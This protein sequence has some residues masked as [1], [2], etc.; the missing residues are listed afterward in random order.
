[1]AKAKTYS[2]E[3]WKHKLN[4]CFIVVILISNASKCYNMITKDITGQSAVR[5]LPSQNSPVNSLSQTQTVLWVSLTYKQLPP[6]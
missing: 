1:M 4:D 2:K 6:F 3:R 5:I